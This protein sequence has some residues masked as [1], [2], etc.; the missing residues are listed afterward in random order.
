MAQD[1]RIGK[2][3]LAAIVLAAG[4]G[5]RMRSARAKVLHEIGGS[6][7]VTRVIRALEAAGAAPIVAVAGYQARDVEAAVRNAAASAQIAIAIQA[8]PRGTGDAA[9]SGIGATPPDYAGD[10]LIAYGDMPMLTAATLSAFIRAHYESGAALSFISVVLDNGGAYGRVLRDA[11]GAALAIVEARDASPAELAVREINTGIYIAHAGFLRAALAGLQ[12]KNAQHEFYLTDIVASARKRGLAVQAW[13]ARDAA[14]FAGVNTREELASMETVLRDQVNRR[15]MAAGV[16]FVDPASAYISD[17]A[18]IAADVII[19]PNVQILGRCRVGAETRIEGTAWLKDVEIGERCHIKL[20]VRAE[21]CRIGADSEIGPFANLRAGTDLEGHNRIGNF[22]E[23][24]KAKIGHGTKASHLSYLGDVTI[25]RDT[26]VG[27]GVI[28]VNYDGY[29]KHATQIGDRCM[30]G[31][32][33]QLVAPIKVGNDAYVAS[34]TTI[35]REVS[36]GALVMSNHPQREKPGWTATWRK[37]HGDNGT[38]STS[39]ASKPSGK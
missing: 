20:G 33:T 4:L 3:G 2:G 22:V 30:I 13:R 36:D 19:G 29:E 39:H 38:G 7:M 9:R 14:E 23:T 31:C 35:I 21:E 1:S 32:D 27:C 25:G 6:A 26:N 24:K 8:E 34:G 17:Q 16:T 15:L 10:V 18:E 5:T 12:P 11:D 28:T 37:R